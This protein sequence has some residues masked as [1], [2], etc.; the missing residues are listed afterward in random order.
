VTTND[1]RVNFELLLDLLP[2]ARAQRLAEIR[3]QN[4]SLADELERLLRA[5][6]AATPSFLDTPIASLAALLG[7]VVVTESAGEVVANY[8][9][10]EPIGTGSFSVVWRAEQ[11]TPVRRDVALKMLKPGL[12][13]ASIARRFD[14]ERDALAKLEHPNISRLYDAGI[15]RSGRPWFVMELVRGVPITDYVASHRLSPSDVATLMIDV[16]AA[17]AFAHGRGLIHR[18]IKPANIMVQSIDGRPLPKL[19]DFGIA[20]ILAPDRATLQ[21][22]AVI[23]T[24]TPAYMS[25]EQATFGEVDGRADVYSLGVVLLELLIGDALARDRSPAAVES[26]LRFKSLSRDLCAVVQ[27]AIAADPADRYDSPEHL[28]ADLRRIVEGKKPAAPHRSTRSVGRIALAAAAVLLFL[29]VGSWMLARRAPP[30]VVTP[31]GVSWPAPVVMKQLWRIQPEGNAGWWSVEIDEYARRAFAITSTRD[32]LEI[33]LNTGEI[34][35]SIRPNGRAAVRVALSADKQRL[36]LVTETPGELDQRLVTLDRAGNVLAQLELRGATHAICLLDDR[37]SR[38]AVS[39]RVNDRSH[40]DIYDVTKGQRIA[41]TPDWFSTFAP[42]YLV[43]HLGGDS[44]YTIAPAGEIVRISASTGQTLATLGAADPS[45]AVLRRL[46]DRRLILTGHYGATIFDSSS[47]EPTMRIKAAHQTIGATLGADGSIQLS[48]VDHRI[49]RYNAS[50]A[51][52]VASLDVGGDPRLVEFAH[53]IPGAGSFLVASQDGSLRLMSADAAASDNTVTLVQTP[54]AATQPAPKSPDVAWTSQVTRDG[55]WSWMQVDGARGRVW[56]VEMY[57]DRKLFEID[58]QTGRTLRAGSP[59]GRP[60]RW[61]DV[62]PDG[63]RIAILAGDASTGGVDGIVNVLNTADRT[64]VR[65]FPVAGG[66]PLL[67]FVDRAGTRLAVLR[68]GTPARVEFVDVA[69]GKTVCTSESGVSD[70]SSLV[71]LD[72]R[73]I[74]AHL[75]DSTPLR[76][77]ADTGRTLQTYPAMRGSYSPV[78]AAPAHNRLLRCGSDVVRSYDLT[79]GQLIGV[80]RAPHGVYTAGLSADGKRVLAWGERDAVTVFDAAT[81]KP[82]RHLLQPHGAVTAGCFSADGAWLAICSTDG[83]IRA[84]HWPD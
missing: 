22:L 60:V 46:D 77:D 14:A 68:A 8:R 5:S 6:D 37:A 74:V 67:K 55:G 39:A 19:I 47:D 23:P 31:D 49:T 13:A 25:P 66:S 62:S 54:L 50:T 82:I 38:I 28:A 63:T 65:S 11:V 70:E 29:L 69:T 83:T 58:L 21:T 44:V 73:S 61:A 7:D 43:A 52:P 4:A 16:C 27:R 12:D 84:W 75:V 53:V 32:L 42:A 57:G 20:R 1:L 9:L 34:L 18:D 30:V 81:A 80:Y 10:V 79:T 72:D 45:T 41:A 24:G 51:V 56:A 26:A 33:D 17:I 2:G 64:V 71:Q 36:F 35:R 78:T 48:T 76:I 3:Q 40:I 59:D 15:H